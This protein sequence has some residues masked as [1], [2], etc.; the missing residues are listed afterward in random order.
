M[1]QHTHPT[2]GDDFDANWTPEPNTG[3]FLWTRARTSAGYGHF[4]TEGVFV[5][6]HRYAYERANGQIPAGLVIDHRCRQRLC[7]NPRHLSAVSDFVNVWNRGRGLKQ[8]AWQTGVCLRGH[9]VGPPRRNPGGTK[10]TRCVECERLHARASDKR[11]RAKLRKE[12]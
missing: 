9:I 7:V 1:N 8:S 6:A 4:M 12:K 10:R 11:R 5:L 3:C 2:I